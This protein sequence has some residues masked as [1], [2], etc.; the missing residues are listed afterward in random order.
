MREDLEILP[1]N[2][3]QEHIQFPPQMEVEPSENDNTLYAILDIWCLN[4]RI[5]DNADNF[6][7]RNLERFFKS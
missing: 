5:S 1:L 7:E 3:E 4:S 6:T 2:S